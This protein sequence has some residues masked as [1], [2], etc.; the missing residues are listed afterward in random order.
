MSR[1]SLLVG[2]ILGLLSALPL[3]AV[4]YLGQRLAG[5]PFFPF[6]LFDWLVRVLPGS[7]VTF[8]IDTL[9]M[10]ITRL[11]LG[12]TAATAKLAEQLMALGIFLI[13]GLLFGL[14]LAFIA[15]RSL[16]SLQYA[17]SVGG[18][19]LLFAALFVEGALGFPGPEIT[20]S[21]LWLALVFV[22][23]G[24]LL[25]RSMEAFQPVRPSPAVESGPAVATGMP[26]DLSR[27]RFLYLV[28]AGSFAVVVAALGV[29]LLGREE[30]QS[31]AVEPE[32]MLPDTGLTSGEAASP[33]RPTLE[34]RIEPAPG[35]R[36]EITPDGEFYRIDINTM[37][38][39]LDEQDWRLELGGLVERPLSLTLDELRSRPAVSQMITLSCISNRVGG[40][41]IGTAL[42]TGLRLKDLLDE[43]GVSPQAQELWIEAADGFYESISMQDIQDERTLLVYEMNGAP[44]TP[45]HGFPLRIY[46]P[47]RF[48]MKQPKWITRM[49]L[50]AEHLPGYWV[51]R[52]WS[53][54][55]IPHTTSVIDTAGAGARD[56]ETGILPV[57]GIA[58]AGA[59]GISRVELQVDDGPW[60]PA[61]LREPPLSPLTW[62][63]WRFDW[64]ASPGRHILRVRAYDGDGVL[65]ESAE[66]DPHPN[67]AT[68]IHSTALVIPS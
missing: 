68:G 67:G 24:Y 48:G 15:R 7:L 65:Q 47:N 42:W 28:G 13:I 6:D 10:L 52:G 45:E 36:P 55:A 32:E 63:Q 23:W 62:V 12:P 54:E 33:P 59:R 46:I 30:E 22:F 49:E 20:L 44:L 39:R 66:A 61:T 57:G 29:S 5:L 9:V 37:V 16:A 19:L 25:S 8:G 58:Y 4:F 17:G 34:A 11:G 38:P 2:G 21:F 18:I 60:Q 1:I 14:V 51:D 64:Q 26:E 35:T 41:L 56:P 40:D 31:V 53:E 43:A 27:R 3:L 50:I